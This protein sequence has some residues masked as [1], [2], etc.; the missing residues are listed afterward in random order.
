M[1][2]PLIG[3]CSFT[4]LDTDFFLLRAGLALPNTI[5]P[6]CSTDLDVLSYG[7]VVITCPNT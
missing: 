6:A 4:L 3:M 5:R 2:S 7:Y 1:D